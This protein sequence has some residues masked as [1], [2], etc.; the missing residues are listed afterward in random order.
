MIDIEHIV[1]DTVA[2]AVNAVYSGAECFSEP[3]PVINRF[4]CVTIVEENNETYTRSQDNALQ[5]HHARL[6]Y[7]I[8]VYSDL[9]TG[10]KEQ[11]KGIAAII[12]TTM[13]SM[14]FTRT[15]KTPTPNI[16]RTIYRITM[17]YTVVASAGHLSGTNTVHQMYRE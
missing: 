9:A 14:K 13:Q 6:S 2:K 5:E 1:F 4:P 12:D 8:N 10:A 15:V 11:A 3:E 17:R 7:T 16:E